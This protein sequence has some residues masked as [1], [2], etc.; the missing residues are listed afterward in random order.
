MAMEGDDP[1]FS[2]GYYW[3][4]TRDILVKEEM[5]RGLLETFE[6]MFEIHYGVVSYR[7]L[8]WASN[9]AECMGDYRII[10]SI[11]PGKKIRFTEAIG[12]LH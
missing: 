5:F 3:P 9:E 4:R 2:S 6:N 7:M 8:D 11:N 1:G 10:I 12:N